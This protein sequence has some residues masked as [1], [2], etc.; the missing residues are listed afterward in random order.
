MVQCPNPLTTGDE[1]CLAA[2]P[3]CSSCVIQYPVREKVVYVCAGDW[4]LTTEHNG[5]GNDTLDESARGMINERLG[6]KVDAS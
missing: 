4:R 5:V 6:T 3:G 1:F 2:N